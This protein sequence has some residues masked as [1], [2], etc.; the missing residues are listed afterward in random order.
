VF[1]TLEVAFQ[2][3]LEFLVVLLDGQIEGLLLRMDCVGSAA[4]L[5]LDAGQHVEAA[6]VFALAQLHGL[7]KPGHA[8][9]STANR[10]STDCK[11]ISRQSGHVSQR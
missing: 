9:T 4:K 2:V 6:P 7:L 10:N 11:F 3:L 1:E 8:T 5:S